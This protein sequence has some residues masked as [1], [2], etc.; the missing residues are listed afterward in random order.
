MISHK[1]SIDKNCIMIIIQEMKCLWCVAQFHLWPYSKTSTNVARFYQPLFIAIR[2]LSARYA[3]INK[4]TD[5]TTSI[6]SWKFGLNDKVKNIFFVK[7]VACSIKLRARSTS[8]QSSNN[9]FVLYSKQ[10][11][12]FSRFFVL[13][14]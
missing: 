10:L 7:S 6:H 1:S 3:L 8:W 12:R 11:C 2:V 4:S 14:K 13:F 5:T 9:F